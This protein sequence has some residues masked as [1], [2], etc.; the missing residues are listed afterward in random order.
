MDIKSRSKV[1]NLNPKL[2][3]KKQADVKAT[4]KKKI[5]APAPVSAAAP[6]EKTAK[7]V[8][9]KLIETIEKRKQAQS[10]NQK[11]SL[12]GRPA[13]RR[14]RRPKAAVE[15][16]PT[17]NEDE[18]FA[19]ENDY[20]GLEYEAGIRVKDGADDKGFSLDRVDDFDEELNFD[21]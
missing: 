1:L 12:F 7:K 2:K 15:Y 10:G 20:E 13:G 5:A 21:R 9:Q 16:T 17:N 8:S 6:V 4:A 19:P 11:G 18:N 3:A 14:G